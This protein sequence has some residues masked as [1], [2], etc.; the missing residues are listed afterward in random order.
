MRLSLRNGG[1]VRLAAEGAYRAGVDRRTAARTLPLEN[2]A[3]ECAVSSANRIGRIAVRTEEPHLLHEILVV[4]RAVRVRTEPAHG[5]RND[6][7]R[8]CDLILFRSSYAQAE[9]LRDLLNR[10]VAELRS[11]TLLEHRKRGL[12]ASDFG[13]KFA[14]AEARFLSRDLRL[15]TELWIQVFHSAY[16]M[17]FIL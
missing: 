11:V 15:S 3:A 14:L 4:G 7:H 9:L 5:R 17:D 8:T 12:L 16:I 13:R 1:N 2:L 10:L 6:R